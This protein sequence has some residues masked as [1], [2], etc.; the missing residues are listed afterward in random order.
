MKKLLSASFFSLFASI[1]FGQN[2]PSFDVHLEAQ[3]I[4][5]LPG[6]QSYAAG[7]HDGKWLIFGGRLDGLHQRQPWQSFDNAGHNRDVY[8]IDPTSGNFWHAPLSGIGN[9][10]L[11][12]QL[13]ATNPNFVQRDSLL[14]IVGG[15]GLDAQSVHITHPLMTVVNV[16]AMIQGIVANGSVDTSAL[17][18]FNHANFAVTGGKLLMLDTAFMLVGGQQFDGQYNPMGHNTYT[19]QYTNEIR[20]FGVEGTFPSLTVTHH[21]AVVDT[22]ELHRRDYNVTYMTDGQELSINAWSGVFQYNADL[23]FLHPVEISAQ[24]AVAPIS[25]FSQYLNHYHCPTMSLWEDSSQTMHTVFFGGIAEY[26]YDDNGTLVHD[27]DVPFVKTIANVT[28][29]ANSYTEHK[30]SAEMPALLGAGAEFFP[31]ENLTYEDANIILLDSVGTDSV[32]VGYI[33]G[34]I[35]S[36]AR[37]VFFGGQTNAS[38]ASPTLYKVYLVKNTSIGLEENAPTKKRDFGVQLVPNPASSPLKIAFNTPLEND[39]SLAIYSMDGKKIWS[40][41]RLKE[42]L[43]DFTAHQFS[44]PAGTYLLKLEDE[45]GGQE[46][47]FIWNN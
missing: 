35:S 10:T 9:D 1:A 32:H 37:N 12:A 25:S 13:A 2:A 27:T 26:Y 21:S 30:L 23:P 45:R 7:E 38:T 17:A 4:T 47:V 43:S 24:H 36:P 16:P 18:S 28:K 20:R 19:Q 15:Y 29:K 46:V 31:L 41:K 3:T 39:A 8:V 33:Y 6:I 5:N 14:F 44:A 11:E 34:G 22:A 40:K 42:G